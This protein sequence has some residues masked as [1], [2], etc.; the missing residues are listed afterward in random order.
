MHHCQCSHLI[1]ERNIMLK[2]CDIPTVYGGSTIPP[3][4]SKACS[5]YSHFAILA[6]GMLIGF[7]I[8]YALVRFET[9]TGSYCNFIKAS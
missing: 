1:A 7:S 4:E 6:T 2:M 3:K 9:L 5:L 8:G